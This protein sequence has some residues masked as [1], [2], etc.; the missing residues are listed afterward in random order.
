MLSILADRS[1]LQPEKLD[2]SNRQTEAGITIDINPLKE[3]AET[4]IRSNREPASNF[5]DLSDLQPEKLHRPKTLTAGGIVTDGNALPQNVNSSIC[6]SR[7]SSSK[8][9]ESSDSH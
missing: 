2:L 7:E 8:T 4:P 9:A 1:N 6:A 3:K 5:T